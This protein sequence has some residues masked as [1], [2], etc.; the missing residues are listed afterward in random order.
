MQVRIEMALPPKSFMMA[1]RTR[2]TG[3]RAINPLVTLRGMKPSRAAL[4][5]RF[6]LGAC[7]ALLK[8][9]STSPTR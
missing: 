5:N 2:R 6:I 3:A 9:S 7:A 4:T 8:I 1:L